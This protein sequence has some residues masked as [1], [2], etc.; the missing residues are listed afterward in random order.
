MLKVR[1]EGPLQRNDVTISWEPGQASAL[2]TSR[3]AKGRDVGNI[4][5]QKAGE[6]IPYDV[7]FAF[8]A[9]AFLPDAPIE[10]AASQ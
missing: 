7:T 5:V 2:D 9:H 1:E 10:K 3:I 4:M 6:D 8:V